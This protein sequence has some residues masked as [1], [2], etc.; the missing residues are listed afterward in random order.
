MRVAPLAA[1]VLIVTILVVG[2]WLLL[3]LFTIPRFTTEGPVVRNGVAVIVA[4]GE[5]RGVKQMGAAMDY[6][7]EPQTGGWWP[8]REGDCTV[9][10]HRP[11]DL[12]QRLNRQERAEREQQSYEAK[13]PPRLV[14]IRECGRVWHVPASSV[15]DFRRAVRPDCYFLRK[16]ELPT[17]EGRA[18]MSA[19]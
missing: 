1:V 4:C 13:L 12:E 19:G 2:A 15:G 16:A 6:A 5:K 3:G 17:K 11:P 14:T 18:D 10:Y 8:V 9:W 7:P